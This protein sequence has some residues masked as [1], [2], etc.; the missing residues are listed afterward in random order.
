MMLYFKAVVEDHTESVCSKIVG[1]PYSAV[2]DYMNKARNLY[3][4]DFIKSISKW[5]YITPIT[6]GIRKLKDKTIDDA[7]PSFWLSFNEP[8][9]L[10]YFQEDEGKGT[11]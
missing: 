2:H 5:K 9:I 4:V 3:S 8:I 10:A 1:T 6:V 7:I 11:V